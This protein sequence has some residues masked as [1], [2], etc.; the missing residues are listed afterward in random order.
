[1]SHKKSIQH[2]D[3]DDIK[4]VPISNTF[5]KLSELVKH[6]PALTGA[7]KIDNRPNEEWLSETRKATPPSS[8]RPVDDV[9]RDAEE[10]FSYRINTCDPQFFAFIPSPVSPVS[11]LGDSLASAFNCYAGSSESG[12]GV[13]AVESSMIAWI[14]ERF[15]LPPSAGGQFV[16]GA[17]MA[18]LTAFTVARDQRLKDEARHKGVAYISDEAHFCITKALR[19]VGLLDSQIRTIRSDPTFRM[20]ADDLRLTIANDMSNGLTP[21]LVVTTCGTTS[22]GAIDPLNEIADIAAEHELWMHVDAAYGGSVAFSTRHRPLVSGIGRADSIAWDPHKW[23]FQTLGCGTILFRE[24][25]QP[26][27]SFASTAH[28]CR[29]I[30][31]ENLHPQNPWNYGLELTRPA[32]H[33]RLWFSLQVLGTDTVDR[34]VSRG[35]ELADLAERELRKLSDWVILTPTSMAILNFRFAPGGV[36]EAEIDRMNSYVSKELA[37]ENV[38]CVLTTQV[39]GVVGLRMCTINPRTTDNDIRCVARTLD[40]I[41]RHIYQRL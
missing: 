30:E 28:F 36:S 23:L 41:A 3:N 15:G 17:S 8:G 9:I 29:D 22:T 39:H 6:P 31:D 33:M 37:A 35:F 25:T 38:A 12:A 20:N 34:M 7:R 19:V 32:R 10:I 1:M 18:C 2:S 16:S 27:K 4:Q 11:C 14:A 40:R 26:L 13:C 21:F 24:K 5:Q